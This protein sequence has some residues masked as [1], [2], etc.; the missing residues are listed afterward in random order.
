MISEPE[1]PE[2]MQE[3]VEIPTPRGPVKG[4]LHPPG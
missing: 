1:E 2:S 3:A 4:I